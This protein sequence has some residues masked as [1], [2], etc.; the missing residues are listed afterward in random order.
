MALLVNRL[1]LEERIARL[2]SMIFENKK[3]LPSN[4]FIAL[5][6]NA[7]GVTMDE[8][9]N[10]NRSHNLVTVRQVLCYVLN[11]NYFMRHTVIGN[12]LK[13]D[14]TT[15]IASIQNVIDKVSIQDPE[16]MELL[17]IA[18]EILNPALRVTGE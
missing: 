7:T 2:E 1:T 8:V 9:Q 12:L 3:Q 13:R 4:E 10:K 18:N 14:R 5:F 6:L 11:V 16:F 17:Q 15:V